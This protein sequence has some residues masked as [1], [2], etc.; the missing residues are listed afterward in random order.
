MQN[1][2]LQ[3]CGGVKV[4]I[5]TPSPPLSCGNQIK[6]NRKWSEVERVS[7]ALNPAAINANVVVCI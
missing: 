7:N 3:I 4:E 5:K 1:F 2:T 6:E